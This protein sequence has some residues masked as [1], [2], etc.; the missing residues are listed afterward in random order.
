M[1]N[2]GV[3]ERAQG[4]GGMKSVLI[5]GASRGIGRALCE[6]ALRRGYRVHALV[7]KPGDAPAGT[8]PH[9]ADVREHEKVGAILK[10]LAPEL[11]HFIAN[12]G[13][14]ERFSPKDPEAAAKVVR[15]FEI[16]GTAVAFS[17]ATLACEW[18]RLGCRD[19]RL[20]TISSLAAGRGMPRTGAYC[21]TKA[22]EFIFAQA[23]DYDLASYGI[24]V[25]AVRPGF[26]HTDLTSYMPFKKIMLDVNDA[27]RIIWNG[28]EREKFEIAFPGGT[29]FF[30]WLR[31]TLPFFLVRRAMHLVA[32]KKWAF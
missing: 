21:A 6:E 1:K 9:V 4:V 32:R 10:S 8:T 13:I 28:V 22:A 19:R 15:V 30:A 29:R 11:T 16:N 3:P 24:R 7:R 12:A 26:I 17:M 14:Q 5:T 25:S 31:D 23:L 20:V 2:S 27:A 18:V